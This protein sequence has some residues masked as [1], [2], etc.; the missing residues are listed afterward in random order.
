MKFTLRSPKIWCLS[1]CCLLFLSETYAAEHPGVNGVPSTP[2]TKNSLTPAPVK[3][4]VKD[5]T[6][7]PLPG[8]SVK[9]KGTSTG[10]QTGIDGQYTIDAKAG[11]VLVFTYVGYMT[12]EVVV[13][14]GNTTNVV[15]ATNTKSLNEVVVTALGI[16]KSQAS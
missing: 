8:V 5:E 14:T 2:A 6:G 9:I 11:D 12:L 1:V 16:S 15:L 10:T 3:G 13:G 4:V 7:L